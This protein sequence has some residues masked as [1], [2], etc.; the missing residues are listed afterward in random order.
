MPRWSWTARP[1][2]FRCQSEAGGWTGLSP[3]QGGDHR[4]ELVGNRLHLRLGGWVGNAG[5]KQSLVWVPSPQ[6]CARPARHLKLKLRPPS[7]PRPLKALLAYLGSLAYLQGSGNGW[8][9]AGFLW[10]IRVHRTQTPGRRSP[11]TRW[12][13]ALLIRPSAGRKQSASNTS[14]SGAWPNPPARAVSPNLSLTDSFAAIPN[15]SASWRGRWRRGPAAP[16]EP[17]PRPQNSSPPPRRPGTSRPPL[18][19]VLDALRKLFSKR[20]SGSVSIPTC[21]PW[22]PW[23]AFCPPATSHPGIAEPFGGVCPASTVSAGSDCWSDE[24]TP[25]PCLL[26]PRCIRS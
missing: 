19:N 25:C 9:L 26:P 17:R 14:P 10:Q 16:H 2:C 4:I 23:S 24:R 1:T 7:S 6:F 18:A 12:A 13:P 15:A 5:H 3:L 8:F 21:V 11:R 22:P 20:F